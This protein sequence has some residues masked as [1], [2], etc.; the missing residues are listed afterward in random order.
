[1]KAGPYIW[2]DANG[3]GRL[4]HSYFRKEFT[5]KSKSAKAVI[6]LFADTNYH[7]FVNG[8]FIGYGPARSYPE[9]PEYD[10]YDI[11]PH[12]RKDK[13]VIAVDVLYNGSGSY[14]NLPVRGGLTC[15][16]K[17]KPSSGKAISLSSEEGWLALKSKAHDPDAPR[18]S[19]AIGAVQLYDSRKDP[20]DWTGIKRPKGDWKPAVKLADQNGWGEL[21]PRMI[22]HLTQDEQVARRLLSA[23][24]DAETERIESLRVLVDGGVVDR[25]RKTMAFACAYV[26]SPRK[27]EVTLGT[28]WGDYFVNGEK[29]EQQ[30]ERPEQQA[31]Q[32]AVARFKKGW[33]FFFGHCGPTLGSW[34]MHLAHPTDAGLMFAADKDKDSKNSFL[35]TP[36][37]PMDEAQPIIDRC[38]PES[39]EADKDLAKLW[40]KW[41][42]PEA[43]VAPAKGNAWFQNGDSIM[44]ASEQIQDLEIPAGK[45]VS[46]VLDQGAIS[47]GRIFVEFDGPKGTVIDL[48][49]AEELKDDRPNYFKMCL[50]SPGER[51]IARGGTQRFETFAPRGFRYLQIVIRNHKKPVTIRKAGTVLQMYP[52]EKV[53]AFECSDPAMNDLWEYGW[54]TL[55]LCSEDVI[56]DCPW[57]ERSLYGGDLLPESATAFATSGDGR[58]IKRCVEIFLQS[59]SPEHGWLQSHAPLPR[60]RGALF[61]YPLLVIIGADWYCR[62]AQDKEFARRCEPVF[63]TMME[64][65]PQWRDKNGVYTTFGRAFISWLHITKQ[66]KCASVNAIIARTYEAWASLLRMLGKKKEAKEFEK[67]GEAL[68]K[69]I[70]RQFWDKET[71]AFADSITEDGSREDSH[72]IV[73]SAMPM[74]FSQTTSA[75]KTE[76]LKHFARKLKQFDPRNDRETISSYDA[77][78]YLGALYEAGEAGFAEYSIRT[79]YRA[80]LAN[81]TG[82]VWEHFHSVKSQMSL[83]HAWSSAPTYYMSTRCLGVRLG[84]PDHTDLDTI[85]IAP[86]AETI[87]W[88][89]GTVAHPLGPVHVDWKVVGDTLQ[90]SYSAPKGAKVKVEPRGRLASLSLFST[91][92]E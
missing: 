90:L 20:A 51:C 37:L 44:P 62:F 36:A 50:M 32:D 77:F 24:V 63:R 31:R 68:I 82:T 87:D 84:F 29:L 10:S 88:A 79:L 34:E 18:F 22:P 21:R 86:E 28:Y 33:N 3:K 26:Y 76:I 42:R 2:A 17:V 92:Q 74:M 25:S 27:Q 14:H 8:T 35:V 66:G 80:V 57:R 16:G 61:E 81:P 45:A 78:Y 48:G 73:S 13:N 23:H 15:W 11:A 67:E 30:P 6:H 85:L 46:V 59:Q 5:L 12:L 69:V 58:L 56:T 38:P 89:R 72:Y 52:Y 83:A 9:F 43:P 54:H 71:G 4:V 70:R 7:L 64:K 39:P 75:Q 49:S 91:C 55:R 40:K 53:G 19:F 60:D 47:L 41:R 1:M 65:L